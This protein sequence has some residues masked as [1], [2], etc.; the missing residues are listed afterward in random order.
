VNTL[1][2]LVVDVERRRPWLGFGSGGMSGAGLLPAG[3]LA[4]WRVSR[5]VDLPI[6]GLGGVHSATDAL[7]YVMAGASLVGIGTA[8]ML[9]VAAAFPEVDTDA[10]PADTIGPFYH[11][12]DLITQPLDLGPPYAKVPDGLGL[13]VELDEQQLRNWRL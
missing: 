9:Q 1:P 7:Q 4:T 8:A 3:V 11:D 6:V 2:G 10:F 12:A 5:A 13:G